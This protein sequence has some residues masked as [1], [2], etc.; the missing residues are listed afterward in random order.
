MELS[1]KVDF[2]R[3]ERRHYPTRSRRRFQ[4]LQGMCLNI[5]PTVFALTE[6]YRN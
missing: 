3:V 2:G 1:W 5:L 6:P 4:L